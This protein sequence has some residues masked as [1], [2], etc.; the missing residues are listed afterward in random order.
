MQA[1]LDLADSGYFVHLLQRESAVGGTMAMLDKTFPTGDCAMCM[2]SPRMVEVAREENIQLHT[3]AEVEAIRGSA[4]DFTAVVR[5]QPRYVDPDKCTGCG[6]C[7]QRCPRVVAGEFD[8]NLGKRKAVYAVMAQAVPSTRVIDSRSCLYFQR[9]KCRACEKFCPAEAI[10]F[11]DTEKRY[12]LQV[13]AVLLSPGLAPYDPSQRQEMG[14]N[15]W[16]N[17]VTSLQFERM[18]SASG[19]TGGEVERPGDGRHPSRIAWIQCVGSR[20]PHNANPWCS[21]VCCMYATKQAV[22]AKEHDPDLEAT[23]FFMDLRAFGKDFDKYVTKARDDYGVRYQRAMI[24]AVREDQKTGDLILRYADESGVLVE[25]AF[26]LVVLSIGL[27]PHAG[28]EE[29]AAAAGIELDGH[30]FVATTPF[31]PVR[32]S[33]E[34]VYVLG[35]ARAPKD[36]PE[37][38]VQGSAAAGRAMALLREARWS[39]VVRRELPQERDVA[40][41]EPRIGVFVCHC[42]VNIAQTVD[43]GRITE[44]VRDLPQVAHAE[45][46]L[47]SCS[48]D[49]QERIKQA[50]REQDLNRVLVASC[51]PRT[52]EPLFQETVRDA[53]LNKYLFELANIREQCAWCHMGDNQ[54]AT[55]K[56]LEI[57]RMH[58]AKMRH[59]EP[60]RPGSVP[61]TRS[62]LVLGGGIAGMTAALSLAEQG[63]GVHLVERREELGGLLRRVRALPE[64]EDVQDFLA[65]SVE[66]V[67]EH[68]GI[69]V[70][71][72]TEVAA[73]EGYVGNYRTTLSDGERIEHGAIVLA[74]GGA[75]YEPAEYGYGQSERVL[76]QRELENRLADDDFRPGSHVA[77][78][79]CIGSREEPHNYCSRVCCQDALKNALAIKKRWP[80]TRVS[81][82]YRDLRSY[83]LREEMYQKAREAGVLFHQFDLENKPE[84]ELAP[85]GI[86]LRA[87]DRILDRPL[88]LKA[89]HL[90]LSAG[91]RPHPE[92]D[93]TAELYRVTQNEDGFFLEAH[94]KLRPVEFPSEGLFLAG[95]AHAPKNLDETV[96]QALA[97]AG[98]AGVL[99]SRE[100]LEVSGRIAR[101]DSD[102]CMACLSCFRICPF[103]APY[104]D[105]EGRVRHNEVKCAGCGLCAGIC[106][107]KAYQVNHF[108]DEQIKAMID[109]ASASH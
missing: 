41:Q 28:A 52:H 58:L 20:D 102:R 2:I 77:M 36:I 56:A 74:T 55:A 26:G 104:I 47:Y 71:T 54:R 81:I 4:G 69:A 79:Q 62:A 12:E 49:S 91:L 25:E 86:T 94:V 42:G 83:G 40:S 59:M 73:T 5:Q 32:T 90:I 15:R 70:H 105:K 21:S 107:S 53:G 64:R 11:E 72:G 35:T 33:R 85:E 38:V 103:D 50:V 44:A 80:E 3:L 8:Q 68:S 39:E 82:F 37:T 98:R 65:R 106:P 43:V 63:F 18:L 14:F 45:D 97:A 100:E 76:T 19:P 60:V 67:L 96:G 66:S 7:E 1:A 23:I 31:D 10:N 108:T 78:I 101:Q 24:S 88:E 95:L 89:D 9:G 29:L 30:R 6:I 99:L 57:V 22:V 27:Q 61:V 13:G 75:E 92:A 84:A 16:G 46:M 109:A 87:R 48:Q 51:T 17:V 93:R 34:G